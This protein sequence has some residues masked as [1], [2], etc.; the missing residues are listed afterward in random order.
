MVWRI[1]IIND[2]TWYDMVWHSK[3]W[4]RM[5][6]TW[7]SSNVIHTESHSTIHKKIKRII[8]QSIIKMI[9]YVNREREFSC[10][11]IKE[12]NKAINR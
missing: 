3:T 4:L 12:I 10:L 5:A 9:W 7:A 1:E 2:M 11:E 8:N 6:K